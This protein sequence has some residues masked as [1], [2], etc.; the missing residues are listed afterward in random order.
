MSMYKI[1][2]PFVYY[3]SIC[4]MKEMVGSSS[5]KREISMTSYQYCGKLLSPELQQFSTWNWVLQK[6]GHTHFQ[7]EIF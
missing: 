1:Y 3:L 2:F 5:E 6:A 7:E 4:Y